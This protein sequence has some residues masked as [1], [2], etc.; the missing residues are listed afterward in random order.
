MR[1]ATTTRAK[2]V[3]LAP[4][5]A[6]MLLGLFA[7]LPASA[8]GGEVAFSARISGSAAFTSPTSVEFDGAGTATHL[9]KF[10][11]AGAAVLGAPTE[12]C[13]GGV[14]GIPNVHTETLTAADGDQLVIRMVNVGCPTGPFTFRGTGHWSVL[15]GTGRFEGVAGRGVNEGNADFATST[16]ELVLT[17]RLLRP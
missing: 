14:L 6:A 16:F 5:L 4:P 9:G 7:L 8:N 2:G 3:A 10:A 17:G 1:S 12:L 15:S 13:P 11:T